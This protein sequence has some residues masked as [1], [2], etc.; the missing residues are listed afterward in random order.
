M[1]KPTKSG[2]DS[3]G[4]FSVNTTKPNWCMMTRIIANALCFGGSKL[5]FCRQSKR[6]MGLVLDEGVNFL[7][8]FHTKSRLF[9]N[10][11]VYIV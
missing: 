3:I 9:N 8:L 1:F 4:Q 10:V 6:G 2:L 7:I 5:Q 11:L